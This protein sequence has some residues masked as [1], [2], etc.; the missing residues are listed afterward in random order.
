MTQMNDY[1]GKKF[2]AAVRSG[3]YA[4]AGEEEAIQLLFKG[5]SKDPERRILD[6]GCG[7]GGTAHYVQEHGWG[8]V[9]GIDIEEESIAD[10]RAKYPSIDFHVGDVMEIGSK[11]AK[12]FDLIYLFNVFYAFPN[13]DLAMANLRQVAKDGARLLLFDYLAYDVEHFPRPLF[14]FS[15]PTEAQFAELFKNN[16]WRID[17]ELN[18]DADYVRWYSAFLDRFDRPEIKS[19][20]PADYVQSVR[21][22]YEALLHAHSSR[23]FGGR[24]YTCTA[25]EAA[26]PG[27]T[28]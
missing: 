18:L 1:L 5:R 2:L 7:R 23:V 26:L 28:E 11:Y 24:L 25:W 8:K 14:S 19:E 27:L 16:G 10:A 3:D 17:S 15:P 13:F 9:T 21:S 20:F 12:Q 22:K 6:M 4:H